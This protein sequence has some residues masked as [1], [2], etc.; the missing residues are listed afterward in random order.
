VALAL[1]V[2]LAVLYGAVSVG[3]T[4]P[5]CRLGT[6]CDKPAAHVQLTFARHGHAFTATTDGTGKYRLKLAPG[7]YVVRSNG[8]M[9]IRPQKINVRAPSTRL[10]FDVDTGIR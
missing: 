9:S 10:D 8:G 1:A 6:P 2:K 7:I 5:V 4:T 3:P